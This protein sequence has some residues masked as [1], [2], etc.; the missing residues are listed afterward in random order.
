MVLQGHT[1]CVTA[2]KTLPRRSECGQSFLASGSRDMT[3]IIWDITIG[4]PVRTLEGHTGTVTSLHVPIMPTDNAANATKP[5]DPAYCYRTSERI[6]HGS[7]LNGPSSDET[8]RASLQLL[9]GSYDCTVRVWD[10]DKIIRDYRWG[11]RRVFLLLM[12]KIASM[13]ISPLVSPAPDGTPLAVMDHTESCPP[14]CLPSPPINGGMLSPGRFKDT[15]SDC[16][17]MLY[18]FGDEVTAWSDDDEGPGDYVGDWLQWV[19]DGYDEDED[20][21][22]GGDDRLGG[23][24]WRWRCGYALKTGCSD[25]PSRAANTE[26]IGSVAE[27]SGSRTMGSPIAP[28]CAVARGR[29]NVR[30]HAKWTRLYAEQK[31]SPLSATVNPLQNSSRHFLASRP[32]LSVFQCHD[33]CRLICSFL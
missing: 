28:W 19:Y 24:G 21:W 11:R 14:L 15:G 3:I 13:S 29:T 10:V 31:V 8:R 23:P 9:S 4:L 33:I 32:A 18:R 16:N 7:V 1:D 25:E 20:D 12:K 5:I 17:D 26:D 30:N 6:R 27:G 22:M 2:L